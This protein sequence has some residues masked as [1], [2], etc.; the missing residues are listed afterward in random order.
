MM[1]PMNPIIQKLKSSKKFTFI[2]VSLV[3]LL[4]VGAYFIST[5][6]R[7]SVQ[8]SSNNPD[9]SQ[10]FKNPIAIKVV[11][12]KILDH[13]AEWNANADPKLL[14]NKVFGSAGHWL[15]YNS[16][17]VPLN[18]PGRLWYDGRLI[19]EGELDNFTLSTNGLHYAYVQLDNQN[20]DTQLNTLIIDGHSYATG[21]AITI[22]AMPDETATT[23]Y[24]CSTNCSLVASHQAFADGMYRN[25]TLLVPF[26][27]QKATAA[28]GE[29]DGDCLYNKA[30]D[31]PALL[32]RVS[33]IPSTKGQI[34]GT[35]LQTCSPNG[36][37]LVQQ[38]GKN[39]F[40]VGTDVTLSLDGHTIDRGAI[41][42]D[43]VND[44]GQVSYTNTNGTGG[45]AIVIKGESYTFHGYT[46]SS[47]NDIDLRYYLYSKSQDHVATV[48]TDK[49]N[50]TRWWVDGQ[51]TDAIPV[52]DIY[53]S[54]RGSPQPE[55]NVSLDDNAFYI[56]KISQ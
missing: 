6:P 12:A 10:A 14:P 15:G 50:Q 33:A 7:A 11:D 20:T 55:S 34:P 19:A 13:L 32:Q 29:I 27:D 9:W 8:S 17:N 1:I 30:V 54:L 46:M 40:L 48:L 25:S 31:L 2:L 42:N 4:G 56:Y 43:T 53:N 37:H 28:L 22:S 5:V 36:K 3:I 41:S 38:V 16:E 52:G 51:K 23:I 35:Q 47:P 44:L 49:N 39:L 45:G 24:D 21:R 26:A 18:Q